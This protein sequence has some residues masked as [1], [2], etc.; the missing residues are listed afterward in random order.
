MFLKA[1]N[2]VVRWQILWYFSL[3]VNYIKFIWATRRNPWLA[4]VNSKYPVQ[5]CKRY[6][7]I[8]F[9]FS[10]NI[11]FS[12]LVFFT[13]LS[14]C[15][16]LKLKYYIY[17]YT[18]DYGAGWVKKKKKLPVWFLETKLLFLFEHISYKEF[19]KKYF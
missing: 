15:F 17:W 3:H 9:R 11:I 10:T 5:I 13:F 7:R 14:S 2:V 16:L 8:S 19:F 4:Q 18:F 6:H 1:C 12:F